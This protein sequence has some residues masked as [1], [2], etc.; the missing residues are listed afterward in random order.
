MEVNN[1]KAISMKR[2]YEGPC[3]IIS[4]KIYFL[5][6]IIYWDPANM[7]NPVSVLRQDTVYQ[8]LSFVYVLDIFFVNFL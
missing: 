1:P 3:D 4:V 5:R 2:A 6:A 7:L 8:G